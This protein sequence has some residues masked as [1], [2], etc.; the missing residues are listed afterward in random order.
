MLDVV[1]RR[2]E[3]FPE[4]ALLEVA[5]KWPREGSGA[6]LLAD[7]ARQAKARPQSRAALLHRLGFTKLV[8]ANPLDRLH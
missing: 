6:L 4:A 5:E 8:A 7:T 1:G 2:M 3:R